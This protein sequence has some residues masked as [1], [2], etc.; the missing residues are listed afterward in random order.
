VKIA[1]WAI[2]VFAL[3]Y[4]LGDALTTPFRQEASLLADLA[5]LAF[6]F[7]IFGSL[8]FL[9]TRALVRSL[10][11]ADVTWKDVTWRREYIWYAGIVIGVLGALKFMGDLSAIGANG[12]CFELNPY[13]PIRMDGERYVYADCPGPN[14]LTDITLPAVL[15]G[16]FVVLAV[17]SAVRLRKNGSNIDGPGKNAGTGTVG[18]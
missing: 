12:T 8:L 18:A 17:F 15:L 4:A 1:F 14:A 10:R 9:A 3:A 13:G 11:D 5:G 6:S 16:G 2:V 7:V